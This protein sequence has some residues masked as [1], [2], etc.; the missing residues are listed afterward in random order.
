MS[1]RYANQSSSAS[2]GRLSINVARRALNCLILG[3]VTIFL[4]ALVAFMMWLDARA[5]SDMVARRYAPPATAPLCFT[6]AL[7][8]VGSLVG[9][10]DR[11]HVRLAFGSGIIETYPVEAVLKSACPSN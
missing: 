8:D 4:L 3:A 5:S 2:T 7:G 11:E 1:A 6:N 10:G 9:R